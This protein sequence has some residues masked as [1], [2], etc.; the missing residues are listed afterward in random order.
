MVCCGDA[1]ISVW[2]YDVLDVTLHNA[3]V[4]QRARAFEVTGF[5]VSKIVSGVDGATSKQ[6]MSKREKKKRD[7]KVT[8]A[9]V[10]MITDAGDT[11]A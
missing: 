11:E 3:L 7:V 6:Q 5:T 1:V 4:Q 8:T 9:V 10:S 2:T